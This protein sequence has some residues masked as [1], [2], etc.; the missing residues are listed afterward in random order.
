MLVPQQAADY[1]A[2]V[3]TDDVDDVVAEDAAEPTLPSPT[4]PP[5]QELPSTSQVA[6][7]LPP[8]PIAQP[9]SSPQQQQPS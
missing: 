7:T 4:P 8:S 6:P 2:N 1:V 9:S 3:A 5:P